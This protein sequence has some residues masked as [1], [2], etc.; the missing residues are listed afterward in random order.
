MSQQTHEH[1]VVSTQEYIP[2]QAGGDPQMPVGLN[3]LIAKMEADGWELVQVHQTGNWLYPERCTFKRPTRYAELEAHGDAD[4]QQCRFGRDPHPADKCDIRAREGLKRA[5]EGP[6]VDQLGRFHSGVVYGVLHLIDAVVAVGG[7]TTPRELADWL[8][9]P[10]GPEVNPQ[11]RE[12]GE[13]MIALI[14]GYLRG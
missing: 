12:Q 9:G 13:A 6:Q 10:G 14:C 8:E 3:E 5:L 7:Q 2:A 11:N 1:K 4:W